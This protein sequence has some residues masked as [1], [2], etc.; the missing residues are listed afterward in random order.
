MRVERSGLGDSE[1]PHC[2]RLDLDAELAGHLAG[3]E[4][5]SRAEEVDPSRIFVFGHSVGGML[6]PLLARNASGAI[7]GVVTFG[8][9]ALPWHD[10]VVRTVRR[11]RVLAAGGESKELELE[12]SHFA[13]LHRLVVRE[14]LTPRAAI[15]A[16]PELGPLEAFRDAGEDTLFGRHVAFFQQLDRAVV[17]GAWRAARLP[18]LVLRGEHDLVC[19]VEEAATIAGELVELAGVGHD[20]RPHESVLSATLAFM[21]AER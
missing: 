13:E 18:V 6:A 3:L 9:S 14:G 8:A 20:M 15:D 1:G 19:T 16:H 10:D 7:R 21:R 5:L 12:M 11:Q 2:S 4:A 17:L